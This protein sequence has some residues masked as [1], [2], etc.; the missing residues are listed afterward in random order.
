MCY[1]E[2]E[3]N[4]IKYLRRLGFGEVTVIVQDGQPIRGVRP[5]ESTKF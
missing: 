5:L 2:H 1:T 3:E 4:L